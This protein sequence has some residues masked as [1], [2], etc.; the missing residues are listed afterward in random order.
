L[1]ATGVVQAELLEKLGKFREVQI[2]AVVHRGLEFGHHIQGCGQIG[3][4]TL[5]NDQS[6]VE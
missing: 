1:P 2:G 3:F 6:V 4:H 5:N